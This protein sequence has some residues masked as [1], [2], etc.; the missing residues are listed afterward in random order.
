MGQG[1]PPYL[2]LS[3]TLDTK[4][5]YCRKKQNAPKEDTK[6]PKSQRVEKMGN[7]WPDQGRGATL[8]FLK[9]Y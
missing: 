2:K 9:V 8:G 4:S 3:L 6:T 5:C 7:A 1:E